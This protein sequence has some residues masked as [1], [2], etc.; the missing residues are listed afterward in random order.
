VLDG[1][2]EHVPDAPYPLEHSILV[3][4]AKVKNDIFGELGIS[5][6]LPEKAIQMK[7]NGTYKFNVLKKHL[8]PGI[9]LSPF[10]IYKLLKLNPS[11]KFS[12]FEKK[13]ALEKGKLNEEDVKNLNDEQLINYIQRVVSLILK[14]V[15]TRFRV[16]VF[17]MVIR[18]KLLKVVFRLT[19]FS[20]EF[21]QFD[22][23]AGLDQKTTL[24]EKDLY[25]LANFAG[26]YNSIK[27]ILIDTEEK[28]RIERIQEM[29]NGTAFLNKLNK[30]IEKNGARTMKALLPFS[31]LSWSENK[32]GLLDAI[33]AIL[34]SDSI[35]EHKKKFIK[36][37]QKYNNI[38][39]KIEQ[40]LP[41][42]IKKSF[43]K[44]I[45]RFREDCKGR[46]SLLYNI[47]ECYVMARKGV[48]EASKRLKERN[49]IEEI[50][51]IKFMTITELYELFNKN[52]KDIILNK[53][54]IRMSNRQET[55]M[56]WD[57]YSYGTIDENS[58][59]IEGI[60]GSPGI[61]KGKVKVISGIS[62]FS[63]LDHGDILVCKFTDPAWT[64][65][66][67]LASAVISDTGG[68]LSH[69]AIVAR[70]YNIPAVLGTKVATSRLEDN[71]NVIVDG[72]KGIV[73]I[74]K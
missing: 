20:N 61:I 11:N 42:I 59:Y 57:G 19:G 40:K 17:P 26:E 31:N 33:S 52:N 21:N 37:E 68:P 58:D 5:L 44:T 56:V 54:K 53:V 32:E 4:T 70:E 38:K 22:L 34:R 51:D 65:L 69:A 74:S 63:K 73:S 2:K 46:E 24:I 15:D 6:P 27:K 29:E 3:R 62:E 45:K 67:S 64:P 8:N 16:Y 66:F 10:K 14:Y 55:M 60:S 23:L 30:F 50:D 47:E 41:G 36:G 49:Y 71:D 39:N 9:L 72:S 25:E 12:E 1:W 13:L 35:K 28:N 7:D 18:G 43:Q 48:F